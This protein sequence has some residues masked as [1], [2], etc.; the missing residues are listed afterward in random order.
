MAHRDQK[1][2]QASEC[3]D[4]Q[5]HKVQMAY[6]DHKAPMANQ[7]SDCEARQDHTAQRV[8]QDYQVWRAPLGH[9]VCLVWA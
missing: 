2:S 8:H 4:R 9:V 7:A 1:A 5:D 6:P 3:E